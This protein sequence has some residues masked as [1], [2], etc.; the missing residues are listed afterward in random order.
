M[1]WKLEGSNPQALFVMNRSS[2]GILARRETSF[3]TEMTKTPK[4]IILQKWSPLFLALALVILAVSTWY[5]PFSLNYLLRALVIGLGFSVLTV[6]YWSWEIKYPN[7]LVW[8]ALS[9]VLIVGGFYWSRDQTFGLGK[10][11]AFFCSLA[12]QFISTVSA[13]FFT[14]LS[15]LN[16]KLMKTSFLNAELP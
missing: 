4:Q 1:K 12:G 10:V 11:D 6:A 2:G 15:A 16:S 7:R 9:V 5:A 14:G 8:S 3:E 13:V